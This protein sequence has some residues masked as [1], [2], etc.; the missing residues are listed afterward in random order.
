MFLT[1]GMNESGE[2]VSVADVKSGH[3]NLHCPFCSE[4]LIARKGAIKE[5]HFAHAGETCMESKSTIQQTGLPF[6]DIA[7]GIGKSD[8]K[9]LDK[10][11]RY[12]NVWLSQKQAET[13]MYL[14]QGGLLEPSP[15]KPEKYQLTRL[16]RDLVKHHDSLL[17]KKIILPEA[18]LQEQLFPAR[19]AMLQY[20][21]EMNG[22]QAA[23]FYQLRL[24]ALLNQHLYVLKIH[25]QQGSTCFPL[26]KV[27]IT[28]RSE[29][30]LRISEI[31]RDLQQHGEVLSIEI[32]G[33]YRHFGSLERLIHK[34]FRASQFVIGSHTEYFHAIE[35]AHDLSLLNLEALG[36]RTVEGAYCR[37]TYREHAHKVRVGQ[38][39]AKLLN[40][41]H[42]GRPAKNAENLLTDHPDIVEAFHASLSLRKA[43]TKTGKA[44]NTVRKVYAA[45][46]ESGNT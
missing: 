8:I 19:L 44:I 4:K 34:R 20:H 22:T 15:N 38:R 14:T 39:K 5:H 3:T 23:R 13:A 10:F 25:L 16:G 12:D 45:L 36:K 26:I 1:H 27:G 11:Q 17:Q 24:Q 6:Y 41:T 2:L 21:D 42:L 18:T 28:S 7:T 29:L 35:T 46:K 31:K 37:T 40:N 43:N 9:L 30:A 32:A 33:L